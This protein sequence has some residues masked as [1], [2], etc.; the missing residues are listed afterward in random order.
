M[1][2]ATLIGVITTALMAGCGPPVAEDSAAPRIIDLSH[3]LTTFAPLEGELL[4]MATFVPGR[5]DQRVV[6][7]GTVGDGHRQAVVGAGDP[8]VDRF[9]RFDPPELPGGVFGG[10]L[11]DL[12]R[13]VGV[14]PSQAPRLFRVPSGDS[15]D[16]RLRL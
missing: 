11:L 5:A 16:A 2:Y 6:S 9:D 3:E 1:T 12:G 14:A 7:V 10:L 8:V 4:V 13:A 15:I